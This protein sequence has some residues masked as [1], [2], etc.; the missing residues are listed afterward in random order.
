LV[1][2]CSIISLNSCRKV[3]DFIYILTPVGDQKFKR[4]YSC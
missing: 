3:N 2:K 4:P 1:I